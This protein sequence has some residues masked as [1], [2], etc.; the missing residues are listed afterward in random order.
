MPPHFLDFEHPAGE[1]H[2]TKVNNSTGVAAL[3][4]CPGSENDVSGLSYPVVVVVSY[5]ASPSA[6]VSVEM[7][8]RQLGP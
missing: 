6:S 5:F 1:V 3:V 2:I 7:R 8:V 4:A